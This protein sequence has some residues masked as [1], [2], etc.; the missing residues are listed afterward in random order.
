MALFQGAAIR[1]EHINKKGINANDLIIAKK[2]KQGHAAKIAE[3][4]MSMKSVKS[5]A[6][7]VKT[8]GKA[9][10]EGSPSTMASP[11]HTL[12][13]SMDNE[14]ETKELLQM[15]IMLLLNCS[16]R[17]RGLENISFYSHQGPKDNQVIAAAL[18]ALACYLSL[19]QEEGPKTHKK[20]PPAPHIFHA[21]METLL[22]TEFKEGLTPLKE[23]LGD[24]YK[25]YVNFDVEAA[26]NA[27][28]FCKVSKAFDS[29]TLKIQFACPNIIQVNG[30]HTTVGSIVSRLITSSGVARKLGKAP[31]GWMERALS[32]HLSAIKK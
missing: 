31:M 1:K 24:Y 10:A 12:D 19:V 3:D 15:M 5:E 30:K 27:V 16:D 8:N 20:G 28:P 14:G 6:T 7:P 17:L 22:A 2:F 26:S 21:V 23:A 32:E 29:A 4:I 25:E 11:P 9:N 13:T 18:G